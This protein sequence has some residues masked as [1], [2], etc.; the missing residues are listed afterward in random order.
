MPELPEVETSRLGIKP[1]IDKQTIE[2][3]IIRQRQLRW[4][5]PATLKQQLAGQSIQRVD[6]RGKYL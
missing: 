2:D 6:R 5:I 4:P 1:H 3:V